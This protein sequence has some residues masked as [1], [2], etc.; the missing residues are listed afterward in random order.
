MI[1]FERGLAVGV[2]MLALMAVPA[3]AQENL[4]L[5]K[6]G[7]QLYASDCAICHKTPQ[8]LSKHVGILGLNDY[9][10]E[11]YTASKESAA[12]IAAYVQSV[13]KGPAPAGKTAPSGKR[14]AKG[15]EKGKGEKAKSENGEKAG[16]AKSGEGKSGEPKS[17]EAKPAES[18]PVDSKP[19][20]GKPA[21]TKSSETKSGEKKPDEASAKPESKP[22]AKPEAKSETKS[23][24]KSEAKPAKDDKPAKPD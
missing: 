17:K 13:D 8:G 23:E 7:A 9:L 14:N 20:E 2:G 3:A 4:D 15:D 19:A 10:R 21:E 1:G 6:T 16:E 22:E 18:K 5:G 24:A 12:T 11:H